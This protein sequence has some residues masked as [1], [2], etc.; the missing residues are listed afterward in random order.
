M[1]KGRLIKTG[2]AAELMDATKTKTLED[3]F[4]ALASEEE[5]SV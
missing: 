3:A 5:A 1:A 2:T 4:I